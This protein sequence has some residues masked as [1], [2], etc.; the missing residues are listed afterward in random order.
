MQC[1]LSCA[2]CIPSSHSANKPHVTFEHDA[3]NLILDYLCWWNVEQVENICWNQ[4]LI[5]WFCKLFVDDK[6]TQGWRRPTRSHGQ[7]RWRLGP[8]LPSGA[9]GRWS[10]SL[11]R[12][13]MSWRL[14]NKKISSWF[15]LWCCRRAHGRWVTRRRQCCTRRR[16]R[17]WRP[18]T[19]RGRRR[20]QGHQGTKPFCEKL[21]TKKRFNFT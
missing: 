16:M 18:G 6:A 11:R 14:G 13:S 17:W 19:H 7:W 4:V 15:Q 10:T 1:M 2:H 5:F 8:P 9:A 21:F 12:A 20:A 3:Y